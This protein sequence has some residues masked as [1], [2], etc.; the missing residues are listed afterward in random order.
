MLITELNVSDDEPTPAADLDIGL[1]YTHE[2]RFMPRLLES[3]A[4]AAGGLNV[5]LLFVDNASDG[6]YARWQARLP[7]TTVLH[8]QR[9]LSY[10][11]NLNRVLR[12]ATAPYVLLMNTDMHFDAAE[13]CLQKMVEFMERRPRCGLSVCRL[14]HPGGGYAWPARRFQTPRIIVARRLKLA[15]RMHHELADYFYQDRN[16]F[17]SFEC[18][19]VS[20]C[21]MFLRRAAVMDVGPFDERFTK[22]FEDVDYAARMHRASW[23]VM[24]NG[25][26]YCYHHEQRASRRLLSGDACRHLGAYA[27]WLLKR[28]A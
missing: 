27:R 20:G 13:P 19:W 12:L 8:N 22:Y 1:V 26:T 28:A 2:R 17:E 24:F 10:A 23:Q 5:R 14:Y 4:P 11:E 21:F 3:L 6:E 18:D 9:R 7:R 25:A 16:H 15:R